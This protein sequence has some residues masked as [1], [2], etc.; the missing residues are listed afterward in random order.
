MIKKSLIVLAVAAKAA[1]LALAVGAAMFSTDE[2]DTAFC[3]YPPPC[4]DLDCTDEES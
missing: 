4:E 2:G 3:C 1:V